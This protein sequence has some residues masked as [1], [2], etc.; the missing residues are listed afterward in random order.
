MSYQSVVLADNPI[1]YYRLGEA[2]GTVATDLG[3]QAQNGTLNG[4]ITLA[5]TGLPVGDA[6]TSE[7]FN[8]STGYI[9]VPTTGLPSGSANFT[10]ECWVQFP[11]FPGASKYPNILNLGSSGANAHLALD[12]DNNKLY[13]EFNDATNVLALSASITN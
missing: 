4:G 12:G 9:S 13:F 3:S 5:Q 10:L 1:R 2:S 6:D 11:S 7:L 8:G